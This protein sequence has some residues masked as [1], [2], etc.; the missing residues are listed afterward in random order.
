M[1]SVVLMTTYNRPILLGQSLPQVEREALSIGANF[2]IHDDRSDDEGTLALLAGAGAR[3]VDVFSRDYSR[4]ETNLNTH[5]C[6]GLANIFAFKRL[7]ALDPGWTHLIKVDDDT[8]WHPGG[9]RVMVDQY[10]KAINDEVDVLCLS[11]I[12]TT[13]EIELE[14]H[15][16][17]SITNSCCN[18]SII[19]RRE[20]LESFIATIPLPYIINDGFDTC[21]LHRWAKRY[22]PTAKSVSTK[23]SVVFHTGLTG[24]HSRVEINRNFIGGIDG[25]IVW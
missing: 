23:P 5:E 19:F 22:R 4:P 10:K 2:Y 7:L 17:Y 16:S 11:G 21:F 12:S 13:N 3:G 15:G 8:F 24:V 20:D 6:T 25:I 1:K 14:D 18:A 9:M